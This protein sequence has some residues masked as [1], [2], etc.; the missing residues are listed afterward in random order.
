MFA[1]EFQAEITEGTIEIPAAYRG[2]VMGPVRVIIL[3]EETPEGPDLIEQL[4][5]HPLPV[6]QFTPIPRAELHERS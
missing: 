1:I 6:E 2:R 5:A 3:A 4:L